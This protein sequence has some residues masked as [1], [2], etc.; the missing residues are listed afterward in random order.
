MANPKV[1]SNLCIGCGLCLQLCPAVFALGDDGKSYITD[2][3]GD[4]EENIQSAVD[5][6]PVTAISVD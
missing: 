1:D 3:Q 5:S 4:S 6:C 2:P